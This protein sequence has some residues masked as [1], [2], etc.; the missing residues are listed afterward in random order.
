MRYCLAKHIQTR[1]RQPDRLLAIAGFPTHELIKVAG[2]TACGLFLI[3]ESQAVLLEF[4]EEFFP[5]DLL[6]ALS[7]RIS[8]KIEPQDSGIAGFAPGSPDMRRT[9]SSRLGPLADFFMIGGRSRR[10]TRA[11]G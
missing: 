1:N 4:I 8:G 5:G 11:A 2:L 6:E 10:R 9:G 3:E 7:A